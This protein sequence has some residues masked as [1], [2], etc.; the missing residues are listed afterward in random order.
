[1]PTAV[2]QKPGAA[3]ASS[4]GK[5]RRGSP[6]DAG[7]DLESPGTS[8]LGMEATCR[9]IM[10]DMMSQ[11]RQEGERACLRSELQQIKIEATEYV[12][13]RLDRVADELDVNSVEE[14]EE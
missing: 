7:G 11:F 13:R 8:G 4:S 14:M 6:S 9:K 5:R 3:Q 1:M 10:Q 12:D 2:F